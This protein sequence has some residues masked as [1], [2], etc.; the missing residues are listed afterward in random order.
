MYKDLNMPNIENYINQVNVKF[1]MCN[2]INPVLERYINYPI[3]IEDCNTRPL[4]NVACT[5]AELYDAVWK[6]LWQ[7]ANL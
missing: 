6:I 4:V 5:N 2:I 7:K 1:Y 3:Y